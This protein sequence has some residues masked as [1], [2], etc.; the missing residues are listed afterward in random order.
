[1]PQSGVLS[2]GKIKVVHAKWLKDSEP[3]ETEEGGSESFHSGGEEESDEED[4][5]HAAAPANASDD[6]DRGLDS[7]YPASFSTSRTS[8]HDEEEDL[9]PSSALP[10]KASPVLSK[11]PPVLQKPSSKKAGSQDVGV[12]AGADANGKAK[13]GSSPA[14]PQL[15]EGKRAKKKRSKHEQSESAEGA[16]VSVEQVAKKLKLAPKGYKCINVA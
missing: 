11:P 6:D 1:L 3:T 8:P 13:K 5:Q 16:D 10:G 14:A 7:L 4:H 12:A 2:L 15:D 9:L